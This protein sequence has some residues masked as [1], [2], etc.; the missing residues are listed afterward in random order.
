MRLPAITAHPDPGRPASPH[1]PPAPR[2]DDADIALY[3]RPDG[4]TECGI[5]ISLLPPVGRTG[6]ETNSLPWAAKVPAAGTLA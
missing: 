2:G 5:F 4:A 1:L 6:A 3:D